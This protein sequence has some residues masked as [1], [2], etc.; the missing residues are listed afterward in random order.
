MYAVMSQATCIRKWL[1]NEVPALQS[2]R[3]TGISLYYTLNGNI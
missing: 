3:Y 1:Y 2:D